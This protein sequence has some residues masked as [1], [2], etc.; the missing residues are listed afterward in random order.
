[1]QC[2]LS[3]LV[4]AQLNTKRTATTQNIGQNYHESVILLLYLLLD[5][6]SYANF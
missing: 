2:A 4:L 5:F 3:T 6:M 1:M